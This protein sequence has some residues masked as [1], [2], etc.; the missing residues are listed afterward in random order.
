MPHFKLKLEE[1]WTSF[2]LVLLMLLAVVWSVLASDWTKGLTIL[3]WIVIVGVVLGLLLAKVRHIP[4]IVAH[5][6]SLVVGS[7]LLTLMCWFG[8]ANL[9]A[10]HH[11]R[12]A[13]GARC[14]CRTSTRSGG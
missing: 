5:P 13:F 14:A 3:P 9:D 12:P 4:A 10:E 6:L 1:G 7:A 2:L 8:V 11:I